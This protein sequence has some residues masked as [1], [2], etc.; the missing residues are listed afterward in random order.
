MTSTRVRPRHGHPAATHDDLHVVLREVLAVFKQT[1]L[2]RFTQYHALLGQ[3]VRAHAAR[4]MTGAAE[5]RKERGPIA[6]RRRAGH[7][8]QGCA[9]LV[10]RRRPGRW[11]GGRGR[12][13]RSRQRRGHRH[14]GDEARAPHVASRRG[15]GRGTPRAHAPCLPGARMPFGSSA[16]FT[17]S[18]RRRCAWS[19]KS[20]VALTGSI[21][22]RCVRYSA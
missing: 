14:C 1:A 9:H 10:G 12:R 13:R 2:R 22:P 21:H 6:C 18:L 15:P 16:S 17:R 5:V 19:L 20:N 8:R 7:R 11:T 4:E 3:Q